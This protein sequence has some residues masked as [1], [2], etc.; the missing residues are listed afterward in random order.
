MPLLFSMLVPRDAQRTYIW[1][2]ASGRLRRR[3]Q[4]CGGN[5]VDDSGQAYLCTSFTPRRAGEK[6]FALGDCLEEKGRD[7]STKRSENRSALKH[8]VYQKVREPAFGYSPIHGNSVDDFFGS[9]VRSRLFHRR[10]LRPRRH[11][12][13][14]FELHI[15]S[16]APFQIAALLQHLCT[17]F[18]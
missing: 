11:F 14:F 10:F 5:C 9:E 8:L 1:P 7:R 2:K 15:F 16:S 6:H 17:I 4:G 3:L 12:S 13:A 18:C